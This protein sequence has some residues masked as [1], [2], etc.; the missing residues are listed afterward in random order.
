MAAH[1]TQLRLMQAGSS[2]SEVLSWLSPDIP[3]LEPRR[4]LGDADLLVYR[5]EHIRIAPIQL[6]IVQGRSSHDTALLH[7]ALDL[8]A[9]LYQEADHA[10][11]LWLRVKTLI[12]QALTYSALSDAQSAF[13]RLSHA[14]TLAEP[15][16]YVRIF[17]DEGEPL[18]LLFRRMKDDT[19][20]AGQKN[21]LFKLLEALG[22][23]ASEL[24]ASSL[25]PQPLIEPLSDRE[26]EVLRLIADGLSNHEIADK[27]IIGLGTV[28][29]HINNIFGKLGVKNRTQ[30]VA[31]A[32]EL[33]LL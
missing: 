3:E 12:L 31:R 24:H 25:V 13:D 26:R 18:R 19:R 21:Y 33:N 11:F 29:T 4:F 23:P 30:A 7:E 10:G 17:V 20:A 6:L 1:E 16:G 9:K 5:H 22:E 28:K 8:L 32:R 27:L 15:E 2:A 14:L